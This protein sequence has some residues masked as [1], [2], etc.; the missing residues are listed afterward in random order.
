MINVIDIKKK[1]SFFKSCTQKGSLG[2]PEWF[3]IALLLK[4][5]FGTIIFKSV[6]KQGLEFNQVTC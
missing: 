5:I 2:K 4:I 3:S 6:G 1:K